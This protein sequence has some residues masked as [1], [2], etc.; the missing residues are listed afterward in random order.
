QQMIQH[1][2][3]YAKQQGFKK[4][5]LSTEEENLYEKYGF[6]YI[7]TLKSDAGTM[8]TILMYDVAGE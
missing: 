7:D 1:V 6:V 8:E 2:L 3:E 5:Y 4:V